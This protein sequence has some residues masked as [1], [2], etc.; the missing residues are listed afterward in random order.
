MNIFERALQW[1]FVELFTNPL[2]IVL[3]ELVI[4]MAVMA[5]FIARAK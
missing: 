5:F 2:P 4:I 3:V 1:Y